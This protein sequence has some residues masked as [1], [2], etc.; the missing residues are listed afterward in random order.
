M[1]TQTTITSNDTSPL[2]HHI[3][4]E[5]FL[6][7][8]KI[9]QTSVRFRL[10]L[11]CGTF[12]ALTILATVIGFT[13]I[14]YIIFFHTVI[15]TIAFL[16]FTSVTVPEGVDRRIFFSFA[17]GSVLLSMVGPI[18]VHFPNLMAIGHYSISPAFALGIIWLA[19]AWSQ[20]ESRLQ[21][22]IREMSERAAETSADSRQKHE[23]MSLAL[24]T[25]VQFGE[26]VREVVSTIEDSAAAMR[27]MHDIL[28]GFTGSTNQINDGIARQSVDLAEIQKLS[29]TLNQS[30]AT[31]ATIIGELQNFTSDAHMDLIAL[32][33]SAAQNIAIIEGISN[34]FT[35]LTQIKDYVDQVADRTNLLA[36]NASIEAARLGSIGNGFAVVAAEIDKLSTF[37]REQG[38]AITGIIEKNSTLIHEAGDIVRDSSDHLVR[39]SAAIESLHATIDRLGAVGSAHG[40]NSN[41]LSTGI[42]QISAS[43]RDIVDLTNQQRKRSLEVIAMIQQLAMATDTLKDSTN[44]LTTE[45]TTLEEHASQLAMLSQGG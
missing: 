15:L 32:N 20:H 26:L 34:S 36:I 2:S 24:L 30:Q 6:K 17:C 21:A 8:V 9:D 29:T 16:S 22:K 14:S 37:N 25:I 44:T 31:V 19:G 7:L 18:V 13:H 35:E 23:G 38:E 12:T 11:Y 1:Q 39:Q 28:H 40:T 4:I 45:F 3:T 27:E 42:E 33:S 5:K 43:G 10:T 41:Q